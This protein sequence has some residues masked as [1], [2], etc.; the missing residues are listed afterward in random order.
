MPYLVGFAYLFVVG[1]GKESNNEICY[2]LGTFQVFHVA[3][4]L[5]QN[6]DAELQ[7]TPERGNVC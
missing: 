5:G 1:G 6:W 4:N 3:P 2:L 7:G